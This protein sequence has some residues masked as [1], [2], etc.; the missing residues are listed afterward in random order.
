MEC[1]MT[2]PQYEKPLNERVA[3]N[4]T[5]LEYLEKEITFI[6]AQ[7]WGLIVGVVA[8]LTISVVNLLGA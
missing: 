6:K 1:A 2:T 8:V 4:E 3:S 7:L 5:R